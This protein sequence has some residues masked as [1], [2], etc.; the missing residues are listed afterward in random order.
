MQIKDKIKNAFGKN[1]RQKLTSIASLV[2]VNVLVAAGVFA[3]FSSSDAVTNRL[4]AEHP[5]VA[6]E[7][8]QWY[9][10]GM[11]KAEASEPGMTIEKDPY[12]WNNGDIPIYVRIKMEID[13]GS[14]R[15]GNLQ[16]SNAI[17]EKNEIKNLTDE[18]MKCRI[19]SA[20]MLENGEPLFT[21]ISDTNG[22]AAENHPDFILHQAYIDENDTE[23]KIDKFTYYFYYVDSQEKLIVLNPKEETTRL[24]NY[25]DIP[26]LKKYYLGVFDQDYSI[27]L[28]AEGIPVAAFNEKDNTI[29]NFISI[30]K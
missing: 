13:V 6:L 11:R 18:E 20:L 24:F 7:E 16:G 22:S 14:T 1:R 19:L 25:M 4:S 12:A 23:N 15:T 10:K 2:I 29:E 26:V 21:S 30:S 9:A 28:T 8:P 17:I 27:R 3:Y 5:S